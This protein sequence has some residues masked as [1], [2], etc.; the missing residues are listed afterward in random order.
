[1]PQVALNE[2][3]IV[4]KYQGQNKHLN[5]LT[6][7]QKNGHFPLLPDIQKGAALLDSSQASLACPSDNSSIVTKVG[8]EHWWNYAERR[9]TKN[10]WY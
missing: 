5:S 9:R 1:M 10:L 6:T 7:K 4:F 3:K 8:M 2:Q